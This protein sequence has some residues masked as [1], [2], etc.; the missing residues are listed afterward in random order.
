M[1]MLISKFHRIIQSKVVWGIFAA[2]ICIAFVSVSAPGSRNR[3]TAKRQA[4]ESQI[5]G[6][7]F[8]DEVSRLEFARA[9]QSVRLDYTLMYGP[10]R[11]TE[12]VDRMLTQGAW[13]RIATL[14]KARQLGLTATPEQM[15]SMIRNHPAF[16]NPQ[17]G[18]FDQQI[19]DAALPQIRALTGG[20]TAVDVENHFADEV[21]LQKMMRIPVQGAL[22]TESEIRERFHLYADK[23]T[24]QYAAIPRSLGGTPDVSEEEAK[25]YYE[26]NREE[27]RV[28]EKLRVD[29][30]AFPV[31][32]H[33]EGIEISDDRVASFYEQYKDRFRRPQ[34]EDTP[35]DTPPAYQP[36]EEVKDS[37]ADQLRQVTARAKSVELADTLVAELAD[38]A[39]TFESAAA[40]LG[41]NIVSNPRPFGLTDPVPGVDPTAPFQRAAFALRED[42]THYYSDPVAGKDVVYVIALKKRLNSFI[43]E[44]DVVKAEVMESARMA[45]AERAYEEKAGEI[46]QAL[47][48]AVR[49]GSSF[50]EAAAKYSLEVKTTA[51]FD[52]TTGL[53]DEFGP[54]LIEAAAGSGKGTLTRLINTPDELLAAYVA[55]V[56][57]GDEA[58]A[59]PGMRDELVRGLSN[60]KTALLMAAWQKA[61]LKEADFEDLLPRT[62]DK[63]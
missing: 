59:L 47:A 20:F 17:T 5:A 11:I 48:E 52:V 24:V 30:V 1:A 50:A 14:R 37:I 8:G 51:P 54:Q 22:V 63:S 49:S 60:E 61:L 6:R 27:F 40:K 39:M 62:T 55:D 29:Y 12:E 57:P 33:V 41:L 3:R 56:V 58:V 19:Y 28:P 44:Y 43:P 21:L 46:H 42:A 25:H 10:F 32:D 4:A 16:R 36:F 45:A 23:L 53:E 26:I 35:A 34:A 15:L 38:E 31:A 2:L 18:Q 7:L 13:M 9:Y